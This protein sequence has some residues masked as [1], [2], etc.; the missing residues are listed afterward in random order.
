VVVLRQAARGKQTVSSQNYPKPERKCKNPPA[1]D[2]K[3]HLKKKESPGRPR[4]I[5]LY[6]FNLNR[7]KTQKKV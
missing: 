1:S 2:F 7:K 3:V 6:S 5:P 4:V